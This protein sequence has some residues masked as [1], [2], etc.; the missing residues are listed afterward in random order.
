MST[1]IQKEK[2]TTRSGAQDSHSG[3]NS[4]TDVRHIRTN[5]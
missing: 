3:S 4:K 2:L 1:R 5:F